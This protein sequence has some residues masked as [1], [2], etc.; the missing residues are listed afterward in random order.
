VELVNKADRYQELAERIIHARQ[1]H[2]R[3]NPLPIVVGIVASG[4]SLVL[5]E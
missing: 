2:Q 3:W 1:Q 4:K 5:F